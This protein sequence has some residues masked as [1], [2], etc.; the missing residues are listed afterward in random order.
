MTCFRRFLPRFARRMQAMSTRAIPAFA[1]PR[2]AESARGATVLT[3]LWCLHDG[4]DWTVI[5][6]LPWPAVKFADCRRG[7]RS[8]QG[9]EIRA[10]AIGAGVGEAARDSGLHPLPERNGL[11]EEGPAGGGEAQPAA[12]LVRLIDQDFH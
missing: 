3:A 7:I 12:A 10:Q 4:K 11:D 5:I 6:F 2:N 1:W 8:G 9:A